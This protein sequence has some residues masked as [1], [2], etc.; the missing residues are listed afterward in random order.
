MSILGTLRF[1][2]VLDTAFL[3]AP[4]MVSGSI[5]FAAEKAFA[6]SGIMNSN[7]PGHTAQ[8]GRRMPWWGWWLPVPL[9]SV[10][11]PPA[12]WFSLIVHSHLITFPSIAFL[13][14]CVPSLDFFFQSFFFFCHYSSNVSLSQHFL[15]KLF[16]SSLLS[17]Q[18]SRVRIWVS[19]ILLI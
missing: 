14:V 7:I 1:F 18:F 4:Y 9:L 19:L 12:S 6:F 5:S 8:Q 11:P 10:L 17:F 16:A 13:C 3:A 2:H 15:K